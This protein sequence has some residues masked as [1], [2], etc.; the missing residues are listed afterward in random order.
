[1]G[2]ASFIAPGSTPSLLLRESASQRLK[3]VTR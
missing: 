1:V 2:P 3:A